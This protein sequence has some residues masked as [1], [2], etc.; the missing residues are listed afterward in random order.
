MNEPKRV[1]SSV[2][3]GPL[4]TAWTVDAQGRA[5][6]RQK[7]GWDEQ[8]IDDEAERFRLHALSSGRRQVDWHASWRKWVM[9]P[10]QQQQKGNGNG[11]SKSVI[12]AGRRIDA[13][14]KAMGATDDYIPGTSGPEP[15]GVDQ[16]QGASNI[17][18]L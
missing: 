7:H 10:Y 18:R 1:H 2:R 17:R 6:A 14:L 16:F 13:K 8:H 11:Q 4:P 5:Y 15:L 9:S 3:A 12:E